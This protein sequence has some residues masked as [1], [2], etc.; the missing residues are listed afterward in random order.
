MLTLTWLAC[1]VVALFCLRLGNA[2]T[3]LAALL[4]GQ[5]GFLAE[6]LARTFCALIVGGALAAAGVLLQSITNNALADPGITGINAGA[7]L[8]AIL[9]AWIWQSADISIYVLAAILGAGLAGCG[10]WLLVGRDALD[11]HNA[12]AL[13]LPLAGLAIEALCLTCAS[14]VMLID[15]T[16]Q[17]RYLHWMAGA[18]P[19]SLTGQGPAIGAILIGL[20]AGGFLCRRLAIL[21]LGGDQSQ[22]LGHNPQTTVRFVLGTVILL[23]GAAVTVSGPIGFIGLVVPFVTRRLFSQSL[24]S[25][26]VLAIPAGGMVLML[27][28]LLGRV[29][30][31]PYE[32]DAGI[33]VALIGGPFLIFIL[34]R[35][36]GRG[37]EEQG[38]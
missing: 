26:Y 28:D 35:L 27:A 9:C 12:V 7:A 14:G 29:V 1:G 31:P 13:R 10:L 24:L 36:I 21:T 5:S 25:A 17:S 3:S 22:A 16:M 34:G 2:E 38:A 37:T 19:L 32:F 30:L 11:G 18:M 23:V 4:S 20:L 15:T 6:R 33:V 8:A